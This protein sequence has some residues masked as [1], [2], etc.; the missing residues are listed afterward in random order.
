MIFPSTS[1]CLRKNATPFP[2]PGYA[3][4]G[5][6]EPGEQLVLTAGM[7]PLDANG[8]LVGATD[9]VAQTVQVL[10][11]LENALRAAVL[12]SSMSSTPRFT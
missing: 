12:A 8:V 6:V 1:I 11:N 9:F 10:S 4:V 5:V 7:V 2:P 3:H